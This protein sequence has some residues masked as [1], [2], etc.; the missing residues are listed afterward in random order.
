MEI[1]VRLPST[2]ECHYSAAIYC[3][4]LSFHD[5]CLSAPLQLIKEEGGEFEEESFLVPC[6]LLYMVKLFF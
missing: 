2:V 3:N 4:R 5:N 6:F 1:K